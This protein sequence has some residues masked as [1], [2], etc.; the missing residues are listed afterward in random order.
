MK[1][2]S[3]Q[4]RTNIF[5]FVRSNLRVKAALGMAIPLILI[6]SAISYSHYLREK[7]LLQV[8]LETS[9]RQLSQVALSS[10]RSAMVI[11]D[12]ELLL[13]SVNDLGEERFVELVQIYD[14]DCCLKVS[15]RPDDLDVQQNLHEQGCSE[16]H[17]MDPS[18][19]TTSTL[20]HQNEQI[21][22]ISTPIDTSAECVTC[23]TTSGPH[24]GMLLIDV[25]LDEL[26]TNAL[27]FLRNE[28]ILTVALAL[29]LGVG[30]YFLVHFM[31]VRRVESF[32]MP[33]SKF[34]AGDFS[35]RL[36]EPGLPTDEI[37]TL[38]ISFNNMAEKLEAQTAES[39]ART[40]LRYEAIMEERERIARELHDG[41]AQL[42]GFINTKAIAIR[43]LLQDQ[44][45][46]SAE[47]QLIQLEDAARV[48]FVDVREAI[49][50][51]KLAVEEGESLAS[52]LENYCHQF[53]RLSDLPIELQV[54]EFADLII[55]SPQTEHH[56]LRIVQEALTNVRKHAQASEVYLGLLFNDQKLS[57]T[58]EDNGSGFETR[59]TTENESNSFGVQTMR[60]R[61]E[62]IGAY[63]NL[64]TSPGL[65]TK[66]T[67][68]LEIR[69]DGQH[70]RT[71]S[72]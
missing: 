68:I 16:C 37:G 8:Q 43:F 63:F 61:A 42:L 19:R 66:I 14:I 20:L 12:W 70:A 3:K 72:R 52:C 64:R 23:H 65:G 6:L 69:E 60:E 46:D 49:L 2:T 5:T 4:T 38:A 57:L 27:L 39:R 18:Q 58:I 51:L 35:A 9:A 34:A 50:G 21:L 13:D 67:V 71:R 33:L 15:S 36:P 31:G 25:S 59:S 26:G 24:L 54:D 30:I 56:L 7:E 1:K 62:E 55:L 32:R 45:I 22:R 11:N 41:I 48:V 44:H 40:Q 53:S 29:L 17:D 47:E 10:L 28:L